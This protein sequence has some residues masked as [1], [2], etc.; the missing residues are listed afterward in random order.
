[1]IED[2]HFEGQLL[3]DGH[4]GSKEELNITTFELNDRIQKRFMGD[5]RCEMNFLIK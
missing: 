2:H 4:P 3:W 1:M 5:N